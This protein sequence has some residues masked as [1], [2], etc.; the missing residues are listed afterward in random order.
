METAFPLLAGTLY[1]E[2]SP[3][4]DI[5]NCIAFAFGDT[6]KWWWPRGG[7]GIYWPDGFPMSDD[8]EVLV[9]VFNTYGFFACPDGTYEQGFE[10][11]VIYSNGGKFKHAARQLES[12]RWASKLGEEQDIEHE[13]PEHLNSS[14]YGTATEFLRRPRSD[15]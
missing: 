4:T 2:E 7:F 9:R 1:S 12:G 10:K 13:L 11:V 14:I 3:S 15:G 8:V 6:H 5:Y